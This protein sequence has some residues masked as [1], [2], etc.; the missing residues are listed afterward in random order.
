MYSDL[1]GLAGVAFL[2]ATILP[3]QSEILLV[4]MHHKGVYSIPAL[5][6]AASVGNIAGSCVNWYIGRYI[7]RLE[8]T[9][10]FPANQRTMQRATHIFKTYGLW[11]LLFAWT[12]FIGDPL[13]VV[14]GTLRVR[15]ITFVSVVSIGKIGR[16]ALL[17][18]IL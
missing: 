5:L 6:I 9:R 1:L 12:P 2:A 16:Y 11:S 13:T 4:I 10:F 15:F 14:A 18:Q 7:R 3:A 8:G 17:L